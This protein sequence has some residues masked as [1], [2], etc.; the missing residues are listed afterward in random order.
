M[1][2]SVRTRNLGR[3]ASWRKATVQSL[4]R[5]LLTHERIQTTLPKAKEAQRL[6]EKLITL[7][8]SGSLSARRR[9]I[10]L[11]E[12]PDLV[13]RLFSEVAPRFAS[14]PGGYTRIMHL[15]HRHGDGASMAVLELVELA[16]EKKETRK[17]KEKE[18]PKAARVEEAPEAAPT[19]PSEAP[20]KTLEVPRPEKPKL[21]KSK[22]DKG[23]KE[24]EKPRGFLDGLRRFFKK[25]RPP[26]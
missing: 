10:S 11:L 15:G 26:S 8:K 2:N 12:S 5:A 1:P 23:K 6:A 24:E 7:G 4:A 16:P 25:D 14:R 19:R 18:S 3:R 17:L 9:A 20:K 13:G 21:G 22:K